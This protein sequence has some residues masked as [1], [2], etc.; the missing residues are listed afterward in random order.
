MASG[1]NNAY[2]GSRP[3]GLNR[4][5][6]STAS[7]INNYGYNNGNDVSYMGGGPGVRRAKNGGG[8]IPMNPIVIDTAAAYIQ[9]KRESQGRINT[10]YYST[11][12]VSMNVG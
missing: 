10:G 4:Y 11:S 9:P 2:A 6:G 5:G 3:T 1:M 7:G 8:G 12:T